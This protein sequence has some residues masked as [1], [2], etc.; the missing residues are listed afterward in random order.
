MYEWSKGIVEKIQKANCL[1][2]KELR[3]V[4]IALRLSEIH[5]ELLMESLCLSTDGKYDL[6]HAICKDNDKVERRV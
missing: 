6:S 1:D 3:M 5:E 2:D 4:E